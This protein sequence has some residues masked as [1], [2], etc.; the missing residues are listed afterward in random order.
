VRIDKFLKDSFI[1]TIS[2][3]VTGIIAFVFSIIL[4]RELGAEGLGLYSLIMPVYGLFLCLTTDGLV[5]AIS[6]ISAV[7]SCRR[8]IT[9][10][11]KTL[12]TV[13]AFI[14]LWSVSVA[15]VVFLFNTAIA[16]HIVRDAR[17]AGAL[18]VLAP[19]LVFVPLSAIIKGYFYGLGNYKVTASVDIIE[20]LLRVAI[21]TGTIAVL[22]LSDVENTVAAAYFAL[23]AGELFSLSILYTCYRVQRKRL[24]GLKYKPKTRIQLLFDVFVISFPLCLNGIL[25]S[26]LSMIST[27][28]LPRRLIAAGFSYGDALAAIGKFGGMAL[29][30]SYLPFIVIGS[31]LTVLVPELSLS[32][33]KKDYWSS[34]N[35]IAQVIKLACAIGVSTAIVCLILP[36]M[37]GQLF[38]KRDDLGDMIRFSAVICLFT[39]VSSPTFGIL[40]ALGKQN[41]LLKNSLIISFESLVL[42]FALTGIPGLNIYG[43]GLS[44]IITSLTALVIN[45]REIR[46]ICEIKIRLQDIITIILAGIAAYLFS[47]IAN[48]LF[49]EAAPALR[50]AAVV[51]A[52]F[53]AVLGL[54]GLAM[55]YRTS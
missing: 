55:K 23:A 2:N 41:V 33:S 14:L 18:A 38:Y 49:M 3:M 35:R 24:T 15:L 17:A 43:Y 10:L 6:K 16:A 30:I 13:F 54:N 27:L 42:I 50:A 45:I 4:S 40:N 29:N 19:A 25:S 48:R 12:R 8:E 11:N 21:L 34:E 9:N 51:I 46:K 1:L 26:I 37:L 5:T 7:Y 28:I 31:M 22:A 44:M 20:K 53:G 39:F 36:D 32:M 47:F 52:S